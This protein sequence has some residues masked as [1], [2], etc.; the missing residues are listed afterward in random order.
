[1]YY[2]QL[3]GLLNERRYMEAIILVDGAQGRNGKGP[4]SEPTR[5]FTERSV[6]Y[7]SLFFNNLWGVRCGTFHYNAQ[8]KPAKLQTS[9]WY[10]SST[11]WRVRFSITGSGTTQTGSS[12]IAN[13]GISTRARPVQREKSIPR[14]AYL[15]LQGPHRSNPF[16]RNNTR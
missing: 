5:G 11:G 1:M 2:K 13:F 9:K 10:S 12:A 8:L 16:W 4:P 7:I 14:Q 15:S 3:Q 6:T